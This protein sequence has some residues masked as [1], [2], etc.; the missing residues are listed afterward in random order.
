M[1]KTT[2]FWVIF[3]SKEAAPYRLKLWKVSVYFNL[4]P[5]KMLQALRHGLLYILFGRIEID[6]I[7]TV[8]NKWKIHISEIQ[9]E[10]FIRWN[11]SSAQNSYYLLQ[12]KGMND[13]H[14]C[15][16]I[17]DFG[18]KQNFPSETLSKNIPSL[19]DS[20]AINAFDIRSR[21]WNAL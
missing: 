10:K 12:L 20:V 18:L 21:Q 1:Q 8:Q 13:G 14:Y 9:I 3:C 6:T 2:S 17:V 16:W 19:T 7:K 5:S 15:C 11:E 4:I